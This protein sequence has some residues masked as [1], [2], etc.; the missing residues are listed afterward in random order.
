MEIDNVTELKTM[1]I[2]KI[3]QMGYPEELGALIA[4]ELGS[5]KTLSRMFGYLNHA[6]PKSAEEIVDEMLA[7]KADR[8]RWINKKKAEYYN[9][10]YNELLMYGLDPENDTPNS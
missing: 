2:N 7:I 1:L 3:R 10:K 6:H 8:E 4:N 5:P 9:S